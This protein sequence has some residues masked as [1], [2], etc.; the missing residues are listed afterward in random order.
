MS[1]R[2]PSRN[3]KPPRNPMQTS[4]DDDEAQVGDQ[5]HPGDDSAAEQN[6]RRREKEFVDE[7]R[8]EATDPRP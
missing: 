2:K 1:N 7:D 5:T 8:D 4:P 6:R 3:P